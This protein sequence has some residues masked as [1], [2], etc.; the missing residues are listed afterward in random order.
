MTL[1]VSFCFE[2][3]LNCKYQLIY[4]HFLTEHSLVVDSSFR[5]AICTQQ[6]NVCIFCLSVSCCCCCYLFGIFAGFPL[7]LICKRISWSFFYGLLDD[8]VVCFAI[9]KP[10]IHHNQWWTSQT[11]VLYADNSLGL[12]NSQRTMTNRKDYFIWKGE[13]KRKKIIYNVSIE[14]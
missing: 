3:L 10:F 14:F 11:D 2:T 8:F 5:F 1:L 12:L 13:E 7:D 4:T 6:P 9:E